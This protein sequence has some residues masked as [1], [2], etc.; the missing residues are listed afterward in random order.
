[1]DAKEG[2]GGERGSADPSQAT[3]E[4][5]AKEMGLGLGK[6]RTRPGCACKE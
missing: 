1:M 2:N 3:S 5:A 6:E 4:G